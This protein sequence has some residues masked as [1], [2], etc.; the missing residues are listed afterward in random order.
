[1]THRVARFDI[2]P[3]ESV[4]AFVSI[5]I[6]DDSIVTGEHHPV[7]AN[8]NML[9]PTALANALRWV[10]DAIELEAVTNVEDI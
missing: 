4:V 9:T 1:M 7:T 3:N 6:N 10:A 5:R 2:P 8:R